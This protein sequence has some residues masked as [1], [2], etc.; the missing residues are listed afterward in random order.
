MG[1]L[2]IASLWLTNIPRLQPWLRPLRTVG[3]PML[4]LYFA[5]ALMAVT[6]LVLVYWRHA[7]FG[8]FDYDLGLY[9][10]QMWQLSNGRG[11]MTVRGLHAFGH[12]ANIAHLLLV[13]FYWL[14]AGPNFLNSLMIVAVVLGAI[15]VYGIAH[16]HLR[17]EWHALVPALAFLLHPT[18]GWLLQETYH[19][20]AMA[21]APMFAAYYAALKHRWLAYGLWLAFAMSWKED[22]ALAAFMLGIVLAIQGQKKPALITMAASATWFL[23]ATQVL[24]PAFSPG[25]AFFEG[26]YGDLGSNPIEMAETSVTDPTVVWEHLDNADAVGYSRDLSASYGFT[27]LLS[28]STLL[29]AL[30][31]TAANLLSVQG[32]TWNPR[33]HY[34]SMV[35]VALTISM[36]QGVARPARLGLRRALLGLVMVSVV[37]TS[38]LWGI[39][40]WSQEYEKGFWPLHETERMEL[41][42]QAVALP[43]PGEGVAATYLLV[44]HLTHR[45]HIYGFP[46]P[47]E[48]FY[49]GI[50]GEDPDPPANVDWIVIDERLLNEEHLQIFDG[51]IDSGEFELVMSVDGVIVAERVE[52]GS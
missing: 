43:E 38:V 41:Y 20:D 29:L 25:G 49:W 28:P 10:Q 11:F 48:P 22:V 14:G 17:N 51:L 19:P 31:Q 8:T 5:M 44:P 21:I 26:F 3:G 39:A 6:F 33:V 7:R 18:T 45:E 32:F 40:P 16:H 13:P 50:A 36:A 1:D 47:W 46:N 35:L 30:P 2:E 27:S 42:R 15:P 23:I 4:V 24:I 12:H 34:A 52:P 37:T 9:D